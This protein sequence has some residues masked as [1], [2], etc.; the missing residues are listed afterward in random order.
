MDEDLNGVP[1]PPD[2]GGYMRQLNLSFEAA[3]LAYSDSIL[4]LFGDQGPLDMNISE[5]PIDNDETLA[6]LLAA[7]GM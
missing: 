1:R 3:S 5:E 4:G 6:P 2:R 7:Q